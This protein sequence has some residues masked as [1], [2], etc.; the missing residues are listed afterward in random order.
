MVCPDGIAD[1]RLFLVL[2]TELHPQECVW[3][4]GL[5]IGYLTDVVQEAGA[6]S[7]LGVQTQLTGHDGAEVS[8]LAGVLEEVLPVGRAVLHLTDEADE[9]GVHTMDTEVDDGALP[10]L[11]DLFL[12]LLTHL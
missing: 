11:D 8:G 7:V 6:L 3:Q 12:D 10:R 4:L 1:V 2:L 5:V 9:L